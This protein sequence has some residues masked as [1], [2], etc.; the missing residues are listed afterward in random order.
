MSDHR[1]IR[2]ERALAGALVYQQSD[3]LADQ[4]LEVVAIPD[5]TDPVARAVFTAASSLRSDG[6]SISML[7]LAERCRAEGSLDTVGGEQ[8]LDALT[9]EAASLPTINQLARDVKRLALFRRRTHVAFALNAAAVEGDDDAWQQAEAELQDLDRPSSGG[10]YL[11]PHDIADRLIDSLSGADPVRWPWPLPSLNQ[12][13]GGGARRGQL[14]GIFGPSSHGK[15]LDIE[16]PV[17]TPSGWTTMGALESGDRVFG[18]DGNP[19]T[20][21]HAWPVRHDRP[22]FEV[23]FSDGATI[24][25]DADH[26]WTVWT[27]NA[28][29]SEVAIA[30]RNERGRS[31][32]NDQ[33]HKRTRP[34]TV[35]TTRLAEMVSESPSRLW[36]PTCAPVARQAADLPIDP[37]ILGYWLGDGH[38]RAARRL[39]K[40]GV[41]HVPELYMNGSIEQRLHLLQ[42]I[43]DS[44]GT[45]SKSGQIDISVCHAQLACD[46]LDLV[47]S[48]GI[49]STIRTR[50]AILN[51]R[52]VGTVW[53]VTFTTSMPVARLARKADRLRQHVSG[54]ATNRFVTAVRPVESR[55]VRCI[56]VDAPDRLFLVGRE[57]IA[58]HNSAFLDCCL[59]SMGAA[60]ASC[61]LFVNEM[62]VEERAERIAANL[63]N[64]P[65]STIQRASAG[66]S[67]LEDHHAARLIDAMGSQP[68]AMVA[69]AGWGVEQIIREARRRKPDVVALDIVQKLPFVP[70]VSRTQVLEDAV[71]RL[72][73]FAKDTGAHVLFAGQVNRQRAD[74]TF[75]VPGMADIKDCAELGNGPDNVLFV[76]REQDR[77]TLE[78]EPEGVVRVAKYRGGRLETIDAIFQGEYQRWVERAQAD[79]WGAAA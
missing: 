3:A 77:R 5:L 53:R 44:D 27:A 49:K 73:A 78:M 32:R 13:A 26:Q 74:G 56:A 14:T 20:V 63:A 21:T 10:G 58:T 38:T 30:R 1:S 39:R 22:C 70:G 67:R 51:G 50:P 28:R 16:T 55:P 66:R 34:Q 41:K 33:R 42:G 47:L 68:V 31:T 15:A 60:G 40:L 6:V 76:W 43:V 24:V 36:I 4:L 37:Y 65:F 29:A 17:P 9:A 48:L 64:V 11:T 71:Q 12:L 61:L 59:Q 7:G 8:G 75:P 57:H 62:T 35:T 46:V 2:A 19:T 23:E 72:D 18:L 54:K 52:R 69:C 25:A 45:I 79:S